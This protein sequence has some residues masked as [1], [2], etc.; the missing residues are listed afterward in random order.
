MFSW[1]VVFFSFLNAVLTL[2]LGLDTKTHLVGFR[3]MFQF[4]L[5][6]LFWLPQPWTK[7]NTPTLQKVLK[8][9]PG[10]PKKQNTQDTTKSVPPKVWK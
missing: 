5:K 4:G 3:K 1:N 8:I 9:S 10:L 2:C 6:H 7:I